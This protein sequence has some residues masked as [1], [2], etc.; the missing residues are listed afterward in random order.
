MRAAV[1]YYI[2]EEIYFTL[3]IKADTVQLFDLRCRLPRWTV[4]EA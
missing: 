3:L 2:G 1:D 4:D